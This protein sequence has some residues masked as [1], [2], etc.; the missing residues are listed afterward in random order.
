MSILMKY[1]EEMSH[2]KSHLMKTAP[3]ESEPTFPFSDGKYKW[4]HTLLVLK[5]GLMLA[6]EEKAETEVVAL[7]AIFHDAC[8]YTSEYN[9]H[10]HE[11]ARYAMEY[12]RKKK[13]PT[14]LIANVSYAIDVHV[15]EMNPKTIE[16]KIIQDADTL[17]KVGAMGI[18]FVLLN[19]GANKLLFLD[20]VNKFKIDYAK[21]LDFMA[22]SI[23]TD[24]ARMIMKERTRFLTSFFEQLE[25]ELTI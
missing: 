21:K 9:E 20:V 15:G 24:K 18:S 1:R 2:V 11:A 10:G 22:K 12:L 17:D 3:N 23:W 7:A 25:A 14:E 4:E 8:Y 16:A 13:Y 19:A 6:K 5:S